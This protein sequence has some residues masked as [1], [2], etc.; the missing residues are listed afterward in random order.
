M[1]NRKGQERRRLAAQD[2]RVQKCQKEISFFLR[3]ESL[4]PLLE[5]GSQ[6]IGSPGFLLPSSAI[7]ALRGCWHYGAKEPDCCFHYQSRLWYHP[8]DAGFSD[9]GNANPGKKTLGGQYTK[10]WDEVKGAV[11]TPGGWRC[12]E[13]AML[14]KKSWSQPKREVLWVSACTATGVGLP[15]PL[16]LTFYHHVPW[17][18]DWSYRTYCL[19]CWVLVS[20]C[21]NSCLLLFSLLE[22][23][24]LF[25]AIVP[26]DYIE[27]FW[28]LQRL[29]S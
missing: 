7:R 9:T 16:E 23:E 4:G 20:L 1:R 26:W 14:A 27:Y 12:R 13:C 21:S 15:K 8:H 29:T 2:S 18:P 24:C 11:Q 17:M 25:R 6:D 19:P 28:F 22:W 3:R 5:K 10:P